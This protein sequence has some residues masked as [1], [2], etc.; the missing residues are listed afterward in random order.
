MNGIARI[1]FAVFDPDPED[2]F[3]IGK[4]KLSAICVQDVRFY[5]PDP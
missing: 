4:R 5:E 2:F 3:A 1:G